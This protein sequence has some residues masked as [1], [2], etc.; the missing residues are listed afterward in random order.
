MA[1]IAIY[2]E[3]MKRIKAARFR[4]NNSAT[5]VI[6]GRN[7][8]GK[9]S[10]MDSIVMAIQGGKSIP[11]K[12]V[13]EGQESAQVILETD[14]LIINRTISPD[15]SSKLVVTNRQGV[16]FQSAQ[17][18]L[19]K[20]LGSLSFDP[21]AFSRM[22]P[23]DQEKALRELLGID[24][25]R[26]D[27]ERE[28]AFDERT[29]VNRDIK[30]L[31]AQIDGMPSHD[32]VPAD[33]VS[34]QEIQEALSDA[35]KHNAT[36]DVIVED[37]YAA[38]DAHEAIKASLV[39]CEAEAARLTELLKNEQRKKAGIRQTILQ[40]ESYL[41]EKHTAAAAVKR[42]DEDEIVQK[43]VTVSDTN[44]KIAENKSL[45]DRM[46]SLAKCLD[47]SQLLTEKIK[48]IDTQT[49]DLLLSAK[50]PIPGLAIEAEGGITL[51]GIPLEQASTA[52]QLKAGVAICVAMNP[53]FPVALIRDASLLDDDSLAMV[54][55]F[56]TEH[57]CQ[58]WMERVGDGDECQIVIEDGEITVNKFDTPE[59]PVAATAKN[60]A[61]KP[62]SAAAEWGSDATK[63]EVPQRARK[64]PL[65]I[66]PSV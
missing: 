64:R 21:L 6:G 15:R 33:E 18:M 54:E 38:N 23:A 16:K 47:E 31:Q 62:G 34:A 44:R 28:I 27:A 50:Y 7:A 5:V 61:A 41:A 51:N 59:D 14:D 22:K 29:I 35:K 52:E 1:I 12:P 20:L 43:M 53:A 26:L 13:R 10:L 19:D 9:T 11:A 42:I 63:A 40:S 58:V 2:S 36:V 4:P 46:K 60:G 48:A 30:S 32:D 37:Y 39:E 25:R 45:A 49:S 57:G 17:K 24:T 56:A 65:V 3:N 66:P 55:R 8:Q